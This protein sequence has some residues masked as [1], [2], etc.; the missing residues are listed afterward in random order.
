GWGEP[1]FDK[2]H[3][4]LG[5]AMLSINAVKGFDY[6]GGFGLVDKRGSHV[7]DVFETD[8]DGNVVTRT[9]Y[10][11]GIQGGISNGMPITFRVAFKPVP[12]LMQP[13]E[14]IDKA[15]NVVTLQPK[16]RHDACVLPRAVPIVEAMAAMVLADAY[17]LQRNSKL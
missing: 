10:S 4:K 17:L 3:A 7:N 11:G 8:A 9:N 15:G 14:T 6:G 12:T 13:Q 5:A 16:G 2:L 1:V